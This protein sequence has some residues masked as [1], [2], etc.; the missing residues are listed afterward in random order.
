MT[1]LCEREIGCAAFGSP[2]DYDTDQDNIVR[3]N[4]SQ[5][6]ERLEADFAREGQTEPLVL[7]LPKG[8]YAPVFRPRLV[9]SGTDPEGTQP[10][11]SPPV[12]AN[13]RKAS[14]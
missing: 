6:R 2:P 11:V 10:A 9:I 1:A 8:K 12:R 7:E 5:V 14:K 13:L 4:A 3:V